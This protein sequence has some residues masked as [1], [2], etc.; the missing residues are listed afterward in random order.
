MNNTW[1]FHIGVSSH[2]TNRRI[3]DMATIVLGVSIRNFT[4]EIILHIKL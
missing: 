2:S 3:F 4:H 1:I